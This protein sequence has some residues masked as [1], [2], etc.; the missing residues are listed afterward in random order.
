[1]TLVEFPQ[2]LPA[3]VVV[4]QLINGDTGYSPIVLKGIIPDTVL[5]IVWLILQAK[6]ADI[7]AAD[8]LSFAT[9]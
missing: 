9:T 6:E 5:A 2:I 4:S 8:M 3:I 7:Q 1:M